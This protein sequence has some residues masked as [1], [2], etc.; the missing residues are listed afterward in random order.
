MRLWRRAPLWVGVFVTDRAAVVVVV[1]VT[2]RPFRLSSILREYLWDH[3]N[4]SL[5]QWLIDEFVLDSNTGL[6]NPAIDG[7]YFDDSWHTAPTP[8]P[9]KGN[10]GSCNASPLGGASEEDGYW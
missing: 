9:A 6:G 3:W 5:R 10:W 1:V 7:F 4:A 8:P 2:D